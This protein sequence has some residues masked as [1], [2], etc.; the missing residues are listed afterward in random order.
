M[1]VVM[2]PDSTEGSVADVVERLTGMGCRV[3]RIDADRV[4]LAVTG[5]TPEAASLETMPGV[6]AVLFGDATPALARAAAPAPSLAIAGR[7]TFRVGAHEV[8]GS[9]PFV[10]AGPCS[11]EDEAT[12]HAIA[13]AVARAGAVG[14]RAGAYKPRTSPY[15]Y[16]GS[17][18]EGL[19][20]LR[21]A[22]DAHRLLVVSEVL[23]PVQIPVAARYCDILQVGARNMHNTTLLRELGHGR[24]P[25]LLK[26]G[27]AATI[28][29]WISAAEYVASAGEPRVILCERGIR[30]FETATRNTLDLNAVAVAR[31]RTTLPVFVDPSHGTGRR[32]LV[33]PLALA[34]VAA[35]ASGLLIEAHVEPERALSDADQTIDTDTLARLIARVRAVAACVDDGGL[36]PRDLAAPRLARA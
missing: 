27:F 8:G 35:G 25:V 3:H 14:L 20:L 11:V 1:I 32:S 22:A 17:G 24:R 28:A 2:K 33:E 29:E 21:R 30:T 10:I 34:A 9:E 5:G 6:D 13:A 16:Q 31:E 36:R 19:H 4:T 12:M 18:E 23:D 15:S 26:R 7:A